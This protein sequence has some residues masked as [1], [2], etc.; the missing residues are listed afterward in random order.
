MTGAAPNCLRPGCD[1]DRERLAKLLGMLGSCYDGEVVA[2]ARQAERLR[3]DA[4]LTWPEILVLAMPAIACSPVSAVMPTRT[5][6]AGRACQRSPTGSGKP[7]KLSSA[8]FASSQRSDTWRSSP[9]VVPMDPKTE[10][11]IDC[12]SIG[13]CSRSETEP[14]KRRGNLMLRGAT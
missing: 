10:I 4:G 9:S 3:A 12:C 1:I 11:D 8:A 13:R 14:L 6:G 7:G 5:V 2:A